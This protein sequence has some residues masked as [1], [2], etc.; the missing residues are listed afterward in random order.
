MPL[1]MIDRRCYFLVLLLFYLPCLA[2]PDPVDWLLLH[3]TDEN[4]LPQNS[5][6]DIAMDRL[7]YVWLSTEDGLLRY[8]GN[9]FMRF[10]TDNFPVNSNRFMSFFSYNGDSN[11]YVRAAADNYVKIHDG[12]AIP[13]TGVAGEAKKRTDEA[14]VITKEEKTYLY[15]NQVLRY[16][17]NNELTRSGEY[18]AKGKWDLIFINNRVYQLDKAGSIYELQ[19]K[20]KT[21]LKGDILLDTKYVTGKEK[22]LLTKNLFSREQVVI[23][24]NQCFYLVTEKAPGELTTRLLYKGFNAKAAGM[25]AAYYDNQSGSLFV[26][27]YTK[28]FFVLA[29]R[30]FKVLSSATT[31]NVYYSQFKYDNNHILTNCNTLFNIQNGEAVV[32][33]SLNKIQSDF[34]IQLR[35]QQGY[36]WTSFEH[37]IYRYSPVSLS[38]FKE[39]KSRA[40]VSAMCTDSRG[41]VFFASGKTIQV[42]RTPFE[43]SEPEIFLNTTAQITN[44]KLLSDSILLA[45]SENRSLRI[46][47]HTRQVTEIAA[48]HGQ[49]VKHIFITGTEEAWL[50]TYGNGFFLYK[51]GN[52]TAYPLGKN[53][54]LPVV[55][56]FIQDNN[57]FFWISTNKGLLRVE[58]KA[59]L[60]YAQNRQPYYYHYFDRRDGLNPN[61]FNGGCEPCGLSFANGAI[62]LPSA[63]GLVYFNADSISLQL[64]DKTLLIDRIELDG[65]ILQDTSLDNLPRQFGQLRIFVSTPYLGNRHNVHISYALEKEGVAGVWVPVPDNGVITFTSIPSGDYQLVIRKL[66]GYGTENFIEKRLGI[67]VAKP[68]YNSPG[69][70]VI[71]ALLIIL[72]T[73]IVVWLRTRYIL[74]RNTLLEK[75]IADKTKK[76]HQQT[77]LREKIIN[78]VSHD[79]LTP[80]QFQRI[81]S[82]KLFELLQVQQDSLTASFA[83]EINHSSEQLFYM[84][85]NL[86]S[87]LK[88]YR[89]TH[90]I[91]QKIT[92]LSGL[93][94]EK[95]NIF[96]NIALE[97]NTVIKN[98]I[99]G[100][101]A[102]QVNTQLLSVILHNLLDNAIKV[103]REGTISVTAVEEGGSCI[104]TITDNGPGMREDVV[105]WVNNPL[106]EK[107]ECVRGLGLTMVTELAK[108]LHL[109]I[110][111]AADSGKGTLITVVIPP[112]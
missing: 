12:K 36:L 16:Y 24:C 87:F 64:P 108:M 39:W 66:N 56:C 93:L 90:T 51:N 67:K 77:N 25:E 19:F 100:T 30:K 50:G 44:L 59:L 107:P 37:S 74:Q 86:L 32:K 20:H 68:W 28:G 2:L 21:F 58:K 75:V 111:V 17:R 62:T 14:I 83:K 99:P 60:Q 18:Y 104:I 5:I 23:W 103:S 53:G 47:M 52:I 15:D 7:G 55:H 26:G 81:M 102:I 40:K 31:D 80:L 11:L 109:R 69:F 106:M 84:V 22:L 78:S 29:P 96:N 1:Y 112:G 49:Q 54:Y 88:A 61:E 105:N 98:A 13:D 82:E 46:N 3:Y 72:A 48:L 110:T 33:R 34:F 63:N 65:R 6:K 70:Y 79:I 71:L 9:N 95:I 35:D 101:I 4:G 57:G 94:T 76:L 38:L 97:R 45:G 10:G 91:E 42:L 41:N 92:N 73:W 43:S 27:S 8:D 89:Y 85:S